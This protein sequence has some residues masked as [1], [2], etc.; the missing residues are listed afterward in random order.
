[1]KAIL[2]NSTEKT[3]TETTISDWRDIAPKIDCEI[4]TLIDCGDYSI[5][6]DDC[7]LLKPCDAFF[8][9]EDYPS[10][11]AGNGLILGNGEE[12]ES[13]DCP[14]TVEEAKEKICFF[15]RHDA[16]WFARLAGV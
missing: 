13:C 7:G 8:K 16:Y 10:P 9:H 14:L 15:N 3:L 1:M 2:I 5:Y 4:F 12:G 11:L 6:V